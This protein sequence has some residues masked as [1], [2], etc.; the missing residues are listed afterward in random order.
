MSGSLVE[1]DW[2]KFKTL[3][4]KALHR[5]CEKVLWELQSKLSDTAKNPHERYLELYSLIQKKDDTLAL[6]FNDS[7]RSNAKPQL[8]ALVA[9]NLITKDELDTFSDE[10][11]I[12]VESESRSWTPLT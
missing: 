3:S 11:K 7:R 6:L 12:W 2:K 10:L 1:S 5:Y 8:V 4:T 9:N